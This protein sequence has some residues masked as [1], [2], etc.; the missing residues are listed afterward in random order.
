MTSAGLEALVAG[1]CSSSLRQ[2]A[3]LHLSRPCWLDGAKQVPAFSPADVAML[4]SGGALPAL[5]ALLLEVRLASGCQGAAGAEVAGGEV[6]GQGGPGEEPNYEA[7]VGSGYRGVFEQ[8]SAWALLEMLDSE[9]VDESEWEQEDDDDEEEEEE[10]VE[11]EDSGEAA[12]SGAA[13]MRRAVLARLRAQLAA[14]GLHCVWGPS[15]K[16]DRD[17]A[18]YTIV[19]GWV[20]EQHSAKLLVCFVQP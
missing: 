17:N 12:G 15:V 1:P 8:H 14:Q 6:G 5:E 7:A 11:E 16:G 2:L 20:G 19:K 4:L 13:V 10:G 9:E 18:K 3:L